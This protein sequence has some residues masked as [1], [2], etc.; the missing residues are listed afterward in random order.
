MA[1]VRLL[2]VDDDEAVR[3]GLQGMLEACDFEVVV[4]SN[5]NEALKRITTETFDVLLTDLHMPGAGDGLT[6]ASVMRHMNPKAVTILLSANPDMAKA[7][8]AIRQQTDEIL[9]KPVMVGDM[10]EVIRKRLSQSVPRPHVVL[11]EEEAS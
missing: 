5:V 7:A 3:S 6:V 2:L 9:R 4:A 11:T 8:A 10:V 1:S